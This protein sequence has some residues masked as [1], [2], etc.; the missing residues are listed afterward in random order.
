MGLSNGLDSLKCPKGGHYT[1]NPAGK[2]PEC[3]VHGTQEGAVKGKSN[4]LPSGVER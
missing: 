2:E 3:S 4:V 1:L